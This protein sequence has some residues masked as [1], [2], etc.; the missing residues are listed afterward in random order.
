MKSKSKVWIIVTI[1]AVVFTVIAITGGIM[2]GKYKA[3]DSLCNE[4]RE[5]KEISTDI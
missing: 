4:I 3:V 1:L 2:V 5:G